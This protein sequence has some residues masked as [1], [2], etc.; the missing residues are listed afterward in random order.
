MIHLDKVKIIKKIGYGMFGTTYLANYNGKLYAVKLQHIL[1]K[2]KKKDYKNEIWREFDLYKYIDT[3]NKEE[4][5]FF[6]KLYDY[7]IYDNCTHIQD[8]P[9]KIDFKNKKDEFAQNLKKLDES[10]WCVKYLLDY[11]GNTTLEKFLL[12]RKMT[13]KQIY[14]F[15]LQICKIIYILYEGGYSHNDLHPR[16][17]MINETTKKYFNFMNKKISYEGY[18]LSVIDYGLVLHT[19]F[20]KHNGYN[21]SFIHNRERFAF[22]EMFSCSTIIFDNTTKLNIDC[23]NMGKPLPWGKKG[24]KYDESTKNMILNHPDFYKI[25]K[26]KY[27]KIYTKS[28]KLL[29]DVGNKINAKKEISKII[30]NNNNRYDFRDALNRIIF[31]FNLFFPEESKKYWKWC[32]VYDVLLPKDIIQELLMINNYTDYI[33]YLINK[34]T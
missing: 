17:I 22:N 24:R 25:M 1:E 4:Q 2:D 6:T 34:I 32:S 33:N 26:H 3:L 12:R 23:I 19:K 31:E 29:D 13:Q 21:K 14:S 16:N 7:K 27:V 5:V 30:E 8:R 20:G 9:I 11:K 18:Q 10:D 28:K 15:M